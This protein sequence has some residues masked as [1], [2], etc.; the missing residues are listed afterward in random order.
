MFLFI[1]FL[2]KLFLSRTLGEMR[3]P[4]KASLGF[5]PNRNV[6][7]CVRTQPSSNGSGNKI[8]ISVLRCTIWDEEKKKS[9]TCNIHGWCISGEKILL[10]CTNTIISKC[11]TPSQTPLRFCSFQS[12]NQDALG[13]GGGGLFARVGRAFWCHCVSSLEENSLPKNALSWV[14]FSFFFSLSP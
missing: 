8:W 1:Y 7:K 9:Q 5:E 14:L 2:K 13:G 3:K 4:G 10:Q 12:T 11:P 6:N